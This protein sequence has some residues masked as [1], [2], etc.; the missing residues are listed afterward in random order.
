M[1]TLPTIS[2][3]EIEGALRRSGYLI[4]YR[5]EE[6]LRT[7][8]YQVS[9]NSSYPDPVTLKA[10]EFDISATGYTNIRSHKDMLFSIL[11]IECVNNSYPMAFISKDPEVET[12]HVYEIVF[13]G[14]PAQV[15]RAAKKRPRE[16]SVISQARAVPSLLQRPDRD[17][18]LF[19]RREEAAEPT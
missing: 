18:V 19:F 7:A 4:E 3:Q 17:A 9:A 14:L 2:N 6:V 10:R 12:V 1:A 8:C 15:I 13:S 11:L 5:V 16:A